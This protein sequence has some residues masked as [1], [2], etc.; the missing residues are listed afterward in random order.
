MNTIKQHWESFKRDVNTTETSPE[1]QEL[2][3]RAF[4]A[5]CQTMLNINIKVGD[6]RMSL[7]ASVNLMD[8]CVDEI[9]SFAEKLSE[10]A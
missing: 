3:Q 9:R 8:S 7:D 2:L 5:G 6:A 1:Q 4:Y 10:T